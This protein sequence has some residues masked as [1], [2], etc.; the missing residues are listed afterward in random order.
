MD[1]NK[2]KKVLKKTLRKFNK[3][4]DFKI[5]VEEQCVKATNSITFLS[6]SNFTA[7]VAPIMSFISIILIKQVLPLI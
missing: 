3:K 1:L 2:T 5:E 4:L 6:R 7:G